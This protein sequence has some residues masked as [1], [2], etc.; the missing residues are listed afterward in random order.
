MKIL[1]LESFFGGSHKDFAQSFCDLSCHDVILIT[2]PAR[3]WKWRQ[4]GSALAFMDLMK[5]KNLSFSDFD[6]VVMTGL[7]DLNLIKSLSALPPVLLYLHETQF[8]YPLG[9]GESVDYHYGLKDV[10]NMLAADRIV[11]N[12]FYH[13][14]TFFK[15]AEY[16]LNRMPHGKPSRWLDSI[17]EEWDVVYPGYGQIN[18]IDDHIYVSKK[19]PSCPVILWNH[20]WEHDKNPNAFYVFLK[21]LVKFK[22]KFHLLIL[23]ER[24]SKYPPI[25]DK[26][27]EEFSNSIISSD[28]AESKIEYF[29][30]IQKADFVVSTSLQE[31]FG[32]AIVEAIRYGCLPL[33]PNRLSYG[34]ILEEDFKDF[35]YHDEQDMVDLFIRLCE[36]PPSKIRRRE[37]INSMNRFDRKE[38][39]I[40][41]DSIINDM[42]D[43]AVYGK[44]KKKEW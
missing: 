27:R 1:F 3:H 44:K 37:L 23:G 6:R 9:P 4:A 29:N 25:F 31:N 17:K 10:T 15:E 38:Q 2:L 41:M 8:H 36:S 40:K 33:L 18:G 26:I 13:G 34:E 22:K 32:I 28:Y 16:F 30:L 14:E 7:T 5:E 39:M 12:S 43:Q 19:N 35:L 11:F 42:L 24:F 21:A 20:R